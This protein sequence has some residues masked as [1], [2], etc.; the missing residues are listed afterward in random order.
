MAVTSLEDGCPESGVL[1]AEL[2]VPSTESGCPW[3][4]VLG[5]LAGS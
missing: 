5:G 4:C 3:N 1:A 2:G